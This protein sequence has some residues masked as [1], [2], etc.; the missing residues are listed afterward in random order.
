M[1]SFLNF[2]GH[3]VT[4]PAWESKLSGSHAS[5]F[6]SCL[7]SSRQGSWPQFCTLSDEKGFF[8]QGMPKE[9]ATA[10]AHTNGKLWESWELAT[11][12][13]KFPTWVLWE[14]QGFVHLLHFRDLPARRKKKEEVENR[15]KQ[16][17]ETMRDSGAMERCRMRK[18]EVP[19]SNTG[20]G[21][22]LKQ[23]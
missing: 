10:G 14:R 20:I 9:S 11:Q 3:R 13:F 21:L 4:R 15:C 23:Q 16:M 22:C 19:V 18:N 12:T 17:S 7:F 5:V 6:R 2:L 8:M 1:F